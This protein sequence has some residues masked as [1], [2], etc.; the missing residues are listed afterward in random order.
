MD[1]LTHAVIGLGIGSF[2]EN[3]TDITNPLVIGCVLGSMVP[4]IDIVAKV[5]GDYVYL[6]HH[7]GITHTIPGLA[8]L[9]AFISVGLK[10]FFVVPFMKL[11]FWT[12]LGA[13][14]HSLFDLL[15]S[16]GV[17][18]FNPI[19]TSKK[20]KGVL[21]LYDPIITMLCF[22]LVMI[23][24]KTWVTYV[25]GVAFF[26]IYIIYKF[27]SKKSAKAKLLN[28][29]KDTNIEEI[30]VL[31]AL[32]EPYKWSFIATTDK[33]YIVGRYNFI[34]KKTQEIKVLKRES[35]EVVELF[36]KSNVGKYFNDFTPIYHIDELK[37]GEY[38]ILKSTDLR[39]YFNDSFMHHAT[40]IVDENKNIVQSFFHPYK[41][42]RKIQV[43]E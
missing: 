34:T 13:L 32:V 9:S 20:Q 33:E 25:S 28:H 1:M 27:L 6:K 12:F 7:R 38:T 29:Y 36:N 5:K 42:D 21:M 19:G 39:Y 35:D 24:N 11:F 22:L 4:D 16:Y 17:N 30:R 43:V 15:N 26:S 10:L 8:V 14:S 18:I 37:D 40:V 3:T 31:P 41:V 23:K 2:V